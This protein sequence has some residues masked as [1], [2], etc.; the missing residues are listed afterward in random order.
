MSIDSQIKSIFNILTI[1]KEFKGRDSSV[2]VLDGE[3]KLA[4]SFSFSYCYIIDLIVFKIGRLKD[5]ISHFS[6]RGY[7]RQSYIIRNREAPYLNLLFIF[8][9]DDKLCVDSA[10]E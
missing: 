4:Y 5:Y 2:K 6:Q 10:V 3:R 1:Y 7:Y 8:E 9:E